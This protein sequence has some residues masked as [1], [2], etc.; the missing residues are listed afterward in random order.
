MTLG[1]PLFV[2]TADATVRMV[3][4]EPAVERLVIKDVAEDVDVGTVSDTDV[5][6]A[7]VTP[8]SA[9]LVVVLVKSSSRAAYRPAQASPTLGKS[10]S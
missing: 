6:M 10:P 4:R 5:S 2:G 9:M 3:E 8:A 7:L 1:A